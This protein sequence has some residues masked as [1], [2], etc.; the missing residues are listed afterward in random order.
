MDMNINEKQ[1]LLLQIFSTTRL[2]SALNNSKFIDSECYNR[3]INENHIDKTD[4]YVIR[5]SGIGNPACLLM[6]LY[7]LIVIPKEILNELDVFD[8]NKINCIIEHNELVFQK[9]SSYEKDEVYKKKHNCEMNYIRHI[10]NG[11]I[12]P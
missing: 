4:D 5:K 8:V 3:L 10:R 11:V 6:M 1:S 9:R 12:C 7:A 2:I